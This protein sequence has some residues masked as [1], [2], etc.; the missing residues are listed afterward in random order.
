MHIDTSGARCCTRSPPPPLSS[1]PSPPLHS[2][3]QNWLY[4]EG[5]EEAKSVYAAKLGELTAVGGP[6]EARAAN[7]AA[8]PAALARLRS[9]CQVGGGGGRRLGGGG[10]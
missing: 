5:E 10:G 9:A 1:P 8:L 6:V 3:T 4:D 2:P 7:T